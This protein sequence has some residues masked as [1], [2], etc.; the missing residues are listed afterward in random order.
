MLSLSR[1]F[2]RG[3]NSADWVEYIFQEL[4]TYFTKEQNFDDNFSKEAAFSI[5]SLDIE[6]N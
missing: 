2:Q 4:D 6:K 5:T 3:E 1:I